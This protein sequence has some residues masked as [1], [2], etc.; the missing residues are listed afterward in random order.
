MTQAEER[1]AER[2]QRTIL[3]MDEIHRF[4]R[5]QQDA[6]LPHVER[7]TLTLIGATTENP[8]FELT[9]A[10]L[11]RCRVVTLRALEEEELLALLKKHAFVI[12]DV[13]RATGRSRK[14]VYRWLDK[15]GLREAVADK[16]GDLDD[17]SGA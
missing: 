14:Q 15:H 11:S 13:A 8:S 1:W 2:R 4:N 6:L 7:G 5:G 10:L 12:A 16:D 9:S 3:F 17:D